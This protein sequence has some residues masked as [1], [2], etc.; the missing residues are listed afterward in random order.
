MSFSPVDGGAGIDPYAVPPSPSPARPARTVGLAFVVAVGATALGLPY[1]L[2]WALLAPDIPLV[3]V[4]DGVVSAE[5][6]PEY[7]I[8]GDGW[9]VLLGVAFGV[10]AAVATWALA[11]RSRGPVVLVALALGLVLAGLGAAWLGQRIGLADYRQAVA[12]AA[13]GTR[14]IHP[15]ALRV[16]DVQGWPKPIGVPLVAAFAAAATYT[17][18]AGWSRH[19]S[20]RHEQPADRPVLAGPVSWGSS[21][22]PDRPATPAPPES[23]RAEPPRD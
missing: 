19:S 6:E 12:A 5:P 2:L 15:P 17:A 20:L 9:F 11:R 13:P 14:V 4:D 21:G 23:G 3:K 16:A 18:L 7:F 1:A 10:L 8:A 22:P